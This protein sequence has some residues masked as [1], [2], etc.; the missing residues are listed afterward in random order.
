M[1]AAFSAFWLFVT[2]IVVLLAV[3]GFLIG[4]PDWCLPFFAVPFV[5]FSLLCLLVWFKLLLVNPLYWP[6]R[7]EI[8]EHPLISGRSYRV[9]VVWRGPLQVRA[10]RVVVTCEEVVVRRKRNGD[11]AVD[12]NPVSQAAVSW[13]DPQ[14]ISE[15]EIH[16][17]ADGRHSL[18]DGDKEIQWK[19]VIRGRAYGWLPVFW[20]YPFIVQP[21][22]AAT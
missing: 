14:Q 22:A 7:V 16:I 19:M 15:G 17:P 6:P 5:L 18:K 12:R 13:F 1:F 11:T 20:E 10:T 8:S 2:A 9:Y 4:E 3:Y 21:A